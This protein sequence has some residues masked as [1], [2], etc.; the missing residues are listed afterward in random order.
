MNKNL[1]IIKDLSFNNIIN[2]V[3]E[4]LIEERGEKGIK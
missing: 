4:I 2:I 1:I 3:K